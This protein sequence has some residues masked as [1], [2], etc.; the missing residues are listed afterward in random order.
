[1]FFIN[2]RLMAQPY[3]W[4]YLK[5][6]KKLKKCCCSSGIWQKPL[7]SFQAKTNVKF[8]I[9]CHVW[10]LH[11]PWYLALKDQPTSAVVFTHPR[12]LR[13]NTGQVGLLPVTSNSPERDIVSRVLVGR[14]HLHKECV[15]TANSN[16]TH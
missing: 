16:T 8:T 6:I 1:M 13:T 2:F 4:I 9:F 7:L 10:H 3:I 11:Y 14:P 12:S 15:Y 5:K